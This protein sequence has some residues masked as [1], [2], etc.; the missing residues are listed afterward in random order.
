MHFYYNVTLLLPK[1]RAWLTSS[2]FH[3]SS[4]TPS[5]FRVQR[6]I[7]LNKLSHTWHGRFK[8]LKYQIPEQG[9]CNQS[10]V[11]KPRLFDYS[12]HTTEFLRNE[13]PQKFVEN[14]A[15]CLGGNFHNYSCENVKFYWR[16]LLKTCRGWKQFNARNSS[17]VCIR[18]L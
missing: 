17:L 15:R 2:L 8:M 16:N 10:I 13:I 9:P 1:F 12:Y 5:P 11:Q 6:T 18:P 4:Q 14:F 7:F 3:K